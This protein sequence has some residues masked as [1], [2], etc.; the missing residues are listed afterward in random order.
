MILQ[1]LYGTLLCLSLLHSVS[2]QSI[3]SSRYTYYY[4]LAQERYGQNDIPAAMKAIDKAIRMA[5]KAYE[6]YLIRGVFYYVQR[7]FSNAIADYDRSITLSPQEPTLYYNRGLSWH[8]LDDPY[9][10]C[11]DFHTAYDLTEA[12]GTQPEFLQ[13]IGA[14]LAILCSRESPLYFAQRSAYHYQRGQYTEAV[15]LCD[16]GIAA[17]PSGAMLHIF[18]GNALQKLKDHK[19][20]AA[21]YK[22]GIGLYYLSSAED[23]EILKESILNAYRSLAECLYIENDL[24]GAIRELGSGI[25]RGDWPAQALYLERGNAYLVSGSYAKALADYTEGAKRD[26]NNAELYAQRAL[27]RLLNPGYITLSKKETLTPGCSYYWNCFDFRYNTSKKADKTVLE[28]SLDDCNKAISIAPDN[29]SAYF[30]RAIVK[31]LAGG[32]HC[33]DMRR[34]KELQYTVDDIFLRDCP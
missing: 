8:A 3:D 6:L 19:A 31:V 30:I 17:F 12:L 15:Q 21:A 16:S 2:A 9:K 18:R 27:S 29:G 20:A 23:R 1:K 24:P 13:E 28:L 11:A 32:D 10:A 4:E 22:K 26:P 5:P 14:S 33:D 34:A 25:K 7:D